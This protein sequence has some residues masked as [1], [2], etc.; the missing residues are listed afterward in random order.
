M[1][2]LQDFVYNDLLEDVIKTGSVILLMETSGV[3]IPGIS[4][5]SIVNTLLMSVSSLS[6]VSTLL[7]SVLAIVVCE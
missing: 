7:T 6:I 4:S 5:L 2:V 3:S 1:N